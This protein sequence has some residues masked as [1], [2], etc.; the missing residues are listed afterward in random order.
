MLVTLKSVLLHQVP[1]WF[2]ECMTEVEA[3]KKDELI[4][5]NQVLLRR[6]NVKSQRNKT[7]KRI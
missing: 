6:K 7:V 4:R 3:L 5:K 1:T 2:S